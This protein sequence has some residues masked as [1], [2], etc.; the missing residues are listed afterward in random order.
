MDRQSWKDG[1][2]RAVLAVL[3]LLTL[4]WS[5]GRPAHSEGDDPPRRS[6]AAPLGGIR[7]SAI[8]ERYSVSLIGLPD[9]ELADAMFFSV[10]ALND[11][12]QVVANGR[13]PGT[14]QYQLY[15]HDPGVGWRSLGR[16]PGSVDSYA[17]DINASG[18]VCGTAYL[19][20]PGSIRMHSV[21]FVRQ[22]TGAF[23]PLSGSD[24]SIGAQAAAINDAGQVAVAWNQGE[25]NT[26]GRWSPATGLTILPLPKD[27]YFYPEAINSRGDIVG[28]YFVFHPTLPRSV[29]AALWTA[30]GAVQDLTP[31]LTS[32]QEALAFGINDAELIVG[33]RYDPA[34]EPNYPIAWVRNADGSVVDLGPAR[35]LNPLHNASVGTHY[36]MAVNQTGLVSLVLVDTVSNIHSPAVAESGLIG[37]VWSRLRGS[38]YTVGATD[39]FVDLNDEGQLVGL[40]RPEGG[41]GLPVFAVLTPAGPLPPPVIN[42]VTPNTGT[43]GEEMT[44]TITGAGFDNPVPGFGDGIN[45]FANDEITAT[46]IKA[47]IFIAEDA[48]LGPRAVTVTNWDGQV[49]TL[50]AGFTVVSDSPPPT[51]TGVSP[52]SGA[53][54]AQDLTVVISGSNLLP[55]AAASFGAGITVDSATSGGA[56]STLTVQID[57][58]ATAESGARTLTVT[59]P[60]GQVANLSNAFTVQPASTTPGKLMIDPRKKPKFKRNRQTGGFP[61]VTFALV[62]VGRGLLMG[63][64]GSM[65]APYSVTEGAGAFSL[66]PG[67]RRSVVL[68]FTPPGRGTYNGLLNISSNGGSKTFK[69]KTKVK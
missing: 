19:P 62:N 47:R 45:N 46:S 58:A 12:G 39:S 10:S 60:D 7:A 54:G 59:N 69:F 50:A 35:V 31:S 22:L 61:P 30:E 63:N 52:D 37:D 18:Q 28:T 2:L 67:E 38:G 29:H 36:K 11:E 41:G 43:R 26:A 40:I 9:P 21:A 32:P 51:I 6:A 56:N 25:V 33:L 44:V 20:I 53:S 5:S 48:A 55:G 23:V 64:V 49:A 15:Q 1:C 68:S 16:M 42:A 17:S 4:T 34:T 57:I 3:I 8:P 14:T 66:A 65:D 24:T 27:H 13:I